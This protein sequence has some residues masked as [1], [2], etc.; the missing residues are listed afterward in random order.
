MIESALFFIASAIWLMIFKNENEKD[1]IARLI[2]VI[3]SILLSITGVT[4]MIKGF[5]WL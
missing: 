2:C 5:H 4:F 3:I 1:E